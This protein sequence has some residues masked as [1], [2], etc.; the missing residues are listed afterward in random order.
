MSSHYSTTRYEDVSLHW[1]LGGVDTRGRLHKDIVRG[2]VPIPFPHRAVALAHKIQF[3]APNFPLLTTLLLVAK[4]KNGEVVAQNFVH[5]FVSPGYPPEREEADRALVLRGTPANW[6][7]AEWSAGGADRD[8]EKAEDCCYGGGHGFF[9]WDLHLEG[10]D[11]KKARRV[12][13]LCEASSHRTD[14]PQTD[15]DVFPTTLQISLNGTALYQGVLRNHPHDSRGV[16]SYWRGG[17][18]GYGYLIHAIAEGETLQRVIEGASNGSIKLRCAVPRDA[19]T[20]GGL[21]IYGAECG[22][23]PVSPT[24]IIEW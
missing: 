7:S 4:T 5:F 13:L 14:S 15:D 8:K 9:E 16:L 18:G 10:A 2:A 3:T 12:K 24:V 19:L 11:L 22:R 1:T 17:V 6:T 20:R 21:T 23:F